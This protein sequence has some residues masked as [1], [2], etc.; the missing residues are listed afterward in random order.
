MYE[1]D[2][3]SSDDVIANKYVGAKHSWVALNI[4]VDTCIQ[5]LQSLTK[6]TNLKV[7][8][9]VLTMRVNFT[10]YL[11]FPHEF[12]QRSEAPTRQKKSRISWSNFW[13]DFA[14]HGNPT[15]RGMDEENM[16]KNF[17]WKQYTEEED[18]FAT[19]GLQPFVAR[20]YESERMT[21][22]NHFVP[23]FTEYPILLSSNNTKV[24]PLAECGLT[25]TVLLSFSGWFLAI[26]F[27][28]LLLHLCSCKYFSVMRKLPIPV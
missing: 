20:S 28:V 1:F 24:I 26:V 7:L 21:F 23:L 2:Y 13:S 19:L 12:E 18:C 11:V 14:K 16:V 25:Y 22:W 9:G 4:N 3:A 6:E 15:P 17:T 27:V 8:L 5:D 10:T